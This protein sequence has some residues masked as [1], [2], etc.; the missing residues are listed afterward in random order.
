M[1]A[2]YGVKKFVLIFKE[3]MSRRILLYKSYGLDKSEFP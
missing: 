3:Y 1:K 2:F